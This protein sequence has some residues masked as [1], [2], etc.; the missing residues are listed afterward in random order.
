MKQSILGICASLI[1]KEIEFYANFTSLE[2]DINDRKYHPCSRNRYLPLLS[3]TLMSIIPIVPEQAKQSHR[4]TFASGR[5]CSIC[6][7][8]DTRHIC[9]ALCEMDSSTLY[10]QYLYWQHFYALL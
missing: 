2:Y 7:K 1:Q 10:R 9:T 5:N 8:C 4:L 3:F 6:R